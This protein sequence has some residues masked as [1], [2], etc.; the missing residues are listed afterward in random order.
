MSIYLISLVLLFVFAQTN[1]RI[2][3]IL[4]PSYIL[5]LTSLRGEVG[6]DYVQYIGRAKLALHDPSLFI[7]NE[8]VTVLLSFVGQALNIPVP[9]LYSFIT[10]SI[11]IFALRRSRN[12]YI[13]IL[14]FSVFAI[15]VAVGYLR[16]AL[17]CAFIFLAV[18]EQKSNRYFYYLFSIIA[19][20]SAILVLVTD[21]VSSI[22]LSKKF[23]L[24]S[25]LI[26]PALFLLTGYAYSAV[27]HYIN[28]YTLQS[29]QQ[30][31]GFY[32]RF[33]LYVLLAFCLTVI[34]ASSLRMQGWYQSQKRLLYVLM[35]GSVV[36]FL[37]SG[38][39]ASDRIAIYLTPVL[40]HLAYYER[41]PQRLIAM[42]AVSVSY[43]SF[44]LLLSP[45]ASAHWR[46]TF[47]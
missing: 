25:A 21:Y 12:T 29:Q 28:N 33:L 31:S 22:K 23:F 30:S 26:L 39:T 42:L 3:N 19:H 18:R 2:N 34:P 46:Y 36:V 9:N 20:P 8:P 32:F 37:L 17:A 16:Q 43:F 6:G 35:A 38:A 40:L 4:A 41:R 24:R 44:W 1:W 45:H 27:E 5:L 15:P 47:L 13:W 14:L 10:L 7:L 11:F